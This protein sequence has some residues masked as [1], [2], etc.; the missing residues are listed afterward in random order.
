MVLESLLIIIV[1]SIVVESITELIIKSFIFNKI[2]SFFISKSVFLEYLLSCGYCFSYWATL[3]IMILLKTFNH[4][5]ILL[6]SP[7]NYLF[8]FFIIQRGSNIV[9]GSVDRYFDTRKDIRY[10][11][12]D[13]E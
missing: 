3:F 4:L 6:D 12:K 11:N 10:N 7:L 9:H 2:K 5:P 8:I 1:S 13:R